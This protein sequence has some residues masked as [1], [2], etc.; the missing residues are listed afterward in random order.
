MRAGRWRLR[1]PE[2]HLQFD[3][4]LFEEYADGDEQ[5]DQRLKN[6]AAGAWVDVRKNREGH[7]E[8]CGRE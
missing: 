2:H 3:L 5:G 4:D 7:E 8:T 6:H 1:L